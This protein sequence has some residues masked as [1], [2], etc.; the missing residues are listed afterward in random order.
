MPGLVVNTLT[1]QQCVL[2]L[3]PGISLWDVLW[4][5]GHMCEFSQ[6]T[7]VSSQCK[8]TENTLICTSER[9]NCYSFY[10]SHCKTTIIYLYYSQVVWCMSSH[11][12]WVLLDLHCRRLAL[13]LQTL[14]MCC[15][16]CALWHVC[17]MTSG[18]YLETG[19]L[20][21]VST[22]WAVL[23]HHRVSWHKLE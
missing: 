19:T 15:Y 23:D 14:T 5:T 22:V 7:S 10:F 2:G 16:A 18:M 8:T 9:L 20:W 1:C 4:T 13:R 6:D 11:S 21:N 17:H 12:V 3:S